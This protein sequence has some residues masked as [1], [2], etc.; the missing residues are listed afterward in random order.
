M[1]DLKHMRCCLSVPLPPKKKATEHDEEG[2]RGRGTAEGAERNGTL[3]KSF[4]TKERGD[5]RSSSPHG[6]TGK[7]ELLQMYFEKRRSWC[8]CGRSTSSCVQEPD[9]ALNAGKTLV[10]LRWEN[11]TLESSPLYDAV[12]WWSPI[13]YT[14]NL[15]AAWVCCSRWHQI[16]EENFQ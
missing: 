9:Q 1:H 12:C 4:D 2:C 10:G 3:S 5:T 15:S 13:M 7:E 16:E 14:L 8:L 11:T 6:T